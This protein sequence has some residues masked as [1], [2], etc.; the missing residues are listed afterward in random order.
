M[1]HGCGTM[2][3]YTGPCRH[4]VYITFLGEQRCCKCCAM[5]AVSF[6]SIIGSGMTVLYIEGFGLGLLYVGAV[7][8]AAPGPGRSGSNAPLENQ[9]GAASA[10]KNVRYCVA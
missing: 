4:V 5:G 10:Y 8:A 7:N 1:P 2:T 3:S 9:G 6:V